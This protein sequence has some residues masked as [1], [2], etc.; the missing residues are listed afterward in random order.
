MLVKAAGSSPSQMDWSAAIVPAK[1]SLCKVMV[2]GLEGGPS[3]ERPFTVE[4]VYLLY[5][6]VVESKGGS[7]EAPEGLLGT[8]TQFGVPRLV[9][10]SQR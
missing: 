8:S 10:C 5:C 3:Q 1:G 4:I 6:V 7:K 9:F 2:T